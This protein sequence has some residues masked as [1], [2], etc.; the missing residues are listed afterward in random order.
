MHIGDFAIIYLL[1][2][3]KTGKQ[4][5]GLLMVCLFIAIFQW[6][7]ILIVLLLIG[8][9]FLFNYFANNNSEKQK[10]INKDYHNLSLKPEMNKRILSQQ[11]IDLKFSVIK[12]NHPCAILKSSYDKRDNRA[13][14]LVIGNGKDRRDEFDNN[15][16]KVK[17]A[18]APDLLGMI[19]TIRNTSNHLIDVDWR[20]FVINRSK[21]HIDGVVYARYNKDGKLYPG[22]NTS[23]LLQRHK[24]YLGGN[25]KKLFDIDAIDKEEMR[26][27]VKFNIIDENNKKRSFEFNLYTKLKIIS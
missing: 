23:K 15:L 16:I 17:F 24:D 13:Y 7:T 2:S 6:W 22:E 5:L 21:T 27:D 3:T 11:E 20:S 12:D 9:L 8:F 4:I 18:M 26:Y 19:V 1:F 25:F 10:R 14:W